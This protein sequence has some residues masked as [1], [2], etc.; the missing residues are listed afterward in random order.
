MQNALKRALVSSKLDARRIHQRMQVPGWC[1][2]DSWLT[3]TGEGK[4]KRERS[5]E[6]GE[7]RGRGT[8]AGPHLPN[9]ILLNGFL[10]STPSEIFFLHFI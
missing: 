9:T 7:G 1:Q 6:R 4:V 3:R 2:A 8:R 10:P 5:V